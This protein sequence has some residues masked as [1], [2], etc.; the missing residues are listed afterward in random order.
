MKNIC[1]PI[2]P[3]TCILF[4]FWQIHVSN[5]STTSN[6]SRIR[7]IFSERKALL[8]LQM[9][10]VDKSNRLASWIGEE[11]CAWE[12]VSCSK[13]T[14]HVVKLDLSNKYP[15]DPYKYFKDIE[16]SEN[17]SRSCLE[18]KISP[19]LLDLKH[20]HYLDMSMN[21]FSTIQIPTFLGS[22]KSLRYL[23]LSN[24]GFEGII[25]NQLGNLS[26][27]EF[28]HLGDGPQGWRIGSDY[29]L[30]STSLWWITN[31][32]SLKYL[33]LSGVYLDKVVDWLLPINKLSSLRSLTLA[34]CELGNIPYSLPPNANFTFLTSLNLQ[35]NGFSSLIPPWLLN[36]TFL[37]NLH[38]DGNYF[39]GSIPDLLSYLPSLTFLDLSS[40]SFTNSLP[41]SLC[42]MSNLES[43]YMRFNHLQGELPRCLGRLTSLEVLDIHSNYISGEVPFSM[44]NLSN[45]QKLSLANNPLSGALH[46]LHFQ[47][48]TKLK[49]LDIS[50]SFVHWNVS[51]NWIPLFQLQYISADST[52]MGPRF[53]AW[54]QFQSGIETMIMSNS[55][56]SDVMPDWFEEVHSRIN[57]LDLNHNNISGKL[58]KLER[59]SDNFFRFVCLSSNRFDGLIDS[60]PADVFGIDVARNSLTGNIPKLD[61]NGTMPFLNY[62]SLNDNLLTGT[63]PDYLCNIENLQVI[64]F[65][66]N[67]LIGKVP[68]CLGKL[69]NLKILNLG[70]N[71]FSGQIPS[72]L[73]NIEFLAFLYLNKNKFHGQLPKSLQNLE[74][75]EILD[76]GENG[77][78]GKIP[79]WIGINLSN[80]RILR[81]QSNQFSGNISEELCHLSRLHILNLEQNELNGRIP[82]CF[83]NFTAMI[84]TTTD[85]IPFNFYT[86]RHYVPLSNFMKGRD[87]EYSSNLPRLKSMGLSRNNLVGNIPQQLMLLVGLQSLNLSRNHLNGTIPTSIGNLT[88]LESLDLS[89]NEL[90]GSIPETMSNLKSLS[91]L[92]LSFNKLSGRIPKEDQLQTL[93]DGSI[94]IGNSGLCGKP[95]PISCASNNNVK[96]AADAEEEE[97]EDEEFKNFSF[98]WFYAGIAP[99]FAVGLLGVFSFLLWKKSFRCL[100][101]QLVDNFCIQIVY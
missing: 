31:L 79:V 69:R 68:F 5:G 56:I 40:N 53:P 39:H 91:F 13:T 20:L 17:F 32:N 95:L 66:N 52:N 41:N 16:Y 1:L 88:R 49:H 100:L 87:L 26:R 36:M 96:Q 94:Y 28:L 85:L 78:M 4:F 92:N 93:D 75:L 30:S 65:S 18:G 98:L 24:S 43:L 89:R 73:G 82:T 8:S 47:K 11:C 3:L 6:T 77:F 46:E 23:N 7:C 10:I 99:G 33:D 67:K 19:S 57:Y 50:S 81:L 83:G 64:D 59:T 9:N 86:S 34:S 55:S 58:P 76:L 84:S 72:S 29:T 42:N 54:L 80:L 35:G 27:L 15:F 45:L 25:P 37:E 62:I 51:S 21:N 90:S 101:F 60:F 70:N 71:S 74:K 38:L 2:L 14:N 12:G 63:I 97:E 61:G 48:L 22:L 44:G